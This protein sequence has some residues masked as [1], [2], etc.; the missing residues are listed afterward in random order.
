MRSICI[1][2]SF[3]V[4]IRKSHPSHCSRKLPP[5]CFG[6]RSISFDQSLI[7]HSMVGVFPTIPFEFVG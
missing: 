1:E 6:I 4:G 7:D 2:E 5:Q 3:P